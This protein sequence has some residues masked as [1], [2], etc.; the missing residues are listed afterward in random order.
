MIARTNLFPSRQLFNELQGGFN[1][2]SCSLNSTLL[3]QLAS[4]EKCEDPEKMV[5][6]LGLQW[7]NEKYTIA[8]QDNFNPDLDNTCLTKRELLQQSSKIFDPLGILSPVSVGA[9]LLMQ[10]LWK[11]RYEW[12]EPLPDE[13]KT[14]WIDIVQEIRNV[15]TV[16]IPRCYF[17][18]SIDTN[19]TTEL[20]V[21]TASSHV[22][23]GT[24]VYIVKGEQASLVMSRN[25][26]API[27]EITLPKNG[28]LWEL[29]WDQDWRNI[30]KKT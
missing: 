16:E 2:R 30:Y 6:I 11:E 24:C 7:N 14:K 23:Y 9:K 13:I 12:D 1:L 8:F 29:F 25:R 20:H 15:I 26:V 10:K 4:D 5:K 28:S 19:I 21:F 3:C 27:K 22:A 18:D 17:T